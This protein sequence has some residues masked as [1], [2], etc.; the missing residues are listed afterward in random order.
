MRGYAL[1]VTQMISGMNFTI[2]FI[3]KSPHID[4][5]RK[6]YIKN[7]I[8]RILMF[9]K[10]VNFSIAKG[11]LFWNY[12]KFLQFDVMYLFIYMYFFLLY[13]SIYSITACI[14][15]LNILMFH[16][17]IIVIYAH[18]SLWWCFMFCYLIF[19]SHFGCNTNLYEPINW[20]WNCK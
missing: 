10:W 7:S 8:L 20:N 5:E 6:R 17:F 9:I 1:C 3:C 19:F 13:E 15:L 16:A 4:L 11:S 2:F 12:K 14:I 18:V